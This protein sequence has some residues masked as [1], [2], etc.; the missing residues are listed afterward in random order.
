MN[1]KSANFE[2]LGRQAHGV[3]AALLVVVAL[4]PQA[5][6]EEVSYTQQMLESP[7]QAVLSAEE[8]GRVTI[9]DG[10]KNE[11]VERALDQQFQR[12]DSMMFIHTQHQQE[13]GEY[14]ADD[15]C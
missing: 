13:S 1:L 11:T 14:A 12:I 10:V 6:A 7:S 4:P 2:K 8:K 3:V 9:Y 15:D 5:L